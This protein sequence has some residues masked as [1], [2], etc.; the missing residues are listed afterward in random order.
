MLEDFIMRK[1][2]VGIIGIGRIASKY[3]NPIKGDKKFNLLALCDIKESVKEISQEN[4]TLFYTDYK[5]MLLN[6]EID[7]VVIT[8][9]PTTHFEIAKHCLHNKKNVILEKPAVLN[10]D[11]LN[12][13]FQI[14]KENKVT[15]DVIFHWM[16]G[17][18]VL[19]FK[20]KIQE[21]GE[22]KGMELSVYDPYTDD[23][24]RIKDEYI[25]L[26]GS[27][28]D[29]GINCLSFLSLFVDVCKLHLEKKEYIMDEKSNQDIYSEHMYRMDDRQFSI[30]VDW[31]YNNNHKFTKIFFHK[32]VMYM[33]H[34]S[35][36]IYINN[37]LLVNLNNGD[38]LENHY[39]NYFA[40]Y[41]A[42]SISHDAIFDI[43]RILLRDK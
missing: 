23:S 5:E 26:S 31:R 13:L 40:T 41:D 35:Q 39:K 9:P 3:I 19:Y 29:S 30:K 34:S 7:L 18:E 28:Y 25:G 24:L 37:K 8:T 14:S 32:D 20:E 22:I 43:H 21:F 38:R 42:K 12:T 6:E 1:L 17:N 4:N 15:F 36:S 2:N 10:M 33:D 16:H 27:W 11:E